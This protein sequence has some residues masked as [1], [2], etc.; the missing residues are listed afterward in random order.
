MMSNSISEGQ[1]FSKLNLGC[2]TDQREGD[3]WLNVDA[4]PEC[5]PD[6]VVDLTDR[7]WPFEPNSAEY[8]LASHVFE[9]FEDTEEVL[10][11]CAR[12]LEPG[13]ELEI[14]LPMGLDMKSD[15]DHLPENEWTWRTPEF[16]TGARHWDVDIGLEVVDRDVTLWTQLP[17]VFGFLQRLKVQWLETR[18]GPGEWCFGLESMTGEYV[19]TF[20]KNK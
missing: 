10:R 20:R 19:V 13:G 2:G 15:P 11:E 17:G 1:S 3:E 5:N 8:I 14:R 12:V 4:V 6:V 18:H 7:P 16:Y 9:H